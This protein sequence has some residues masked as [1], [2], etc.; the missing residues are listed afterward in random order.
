VQRKAYI[1][2]LCLVVPCPPPYGGIANWTAMI[3]NYME[4]NSNIDFSIINT[5]ISKRSTDGRTLFDRIV[6]SG[7]DMLKKGKQLN[8]HIK[9]DKLDVIHMTTSGQLAIIRDIILLKIAKKHNIPIVYH[10]RFGRVREISKKNTKE[11]RLLARAIKLASTTIAIDCTTFNELRKRSPDSNIS[12][13]PNPIDI[14]TLPQ[15]SEMGDQT[16]VFLGWVIKTKGIEELLTAWQQVYKKHN[17]WSLKIVGPYQTQYYEELRAVYSFGGVRM[18]GEKSHDEAME[19]LNRSSIFIL[20][21]YTEG[22]PNAVLEAMALGKP[23]IATRVGA[24]PDILADGCGMLIRP[25]CTS[26]IADALDQLIVDP[27]QRKKLAGKAYEKLLKEYTMETVFEKY[28]S[29][30]KS[31][32]A[33]APT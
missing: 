4:G 27:A 29:V 31:L 1:M 26:D 23:V 28:L 2:K 9:N 30:W 18:M 5:A 20:P 6:G 11:W 21:S 25:R 17:N 13:I 10:L 7:F 16:I 8:K 19:I 14:R 3:S 22:F 33:N 32:C 15:R 12:Y 24:I